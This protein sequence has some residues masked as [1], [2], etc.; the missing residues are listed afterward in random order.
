MSAGASL[1]MNV[2]ERARLTGSI[3]RN[4]SSRRDVTYRAGV[5]NYQPSSAYDY[6]SGSLQLSWQL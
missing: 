3:Y 2:T 5:P 4:F 1:N 6:W